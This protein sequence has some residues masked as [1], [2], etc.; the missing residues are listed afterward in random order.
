MPRVCHVGMLDVIGAA[1]VSFVVMSEQVTTGTDGGPVVVGRGRLKELIALLLF[2]LVGFTFAAPCL[3]VEGAIRGRF[4]TG[5]LALAFCRLAWCVYKGT[6]RYRDYFLYLA[7]VVAF[8]VGA[9]LQQ[10]R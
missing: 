7:I 6:F 2:L 3:C 8:C 5:L 10:G 1:P 9:D 4:T